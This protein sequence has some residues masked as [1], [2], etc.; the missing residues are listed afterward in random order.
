L[1][2]GVYDAQSSLPCAALGKSIGRPER[3]VSNSNSAAITSRTPATMPTCHAG[4]AEFFAG[5]MCESVIGGQLSRRAGECQANEYG[6]A[7]LTYSTQ[8]L[9]A[10]P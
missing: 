3:Q 7:L 2:L 6:Y 1:W 10:G 9:Q 5:A 4:G 8:N